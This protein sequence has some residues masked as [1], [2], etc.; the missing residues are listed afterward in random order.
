M[1]VVIS[2][3]AMR[4][5]L[6]VALVLG[7]SSG[8]KTEP[9]AGDASTGPKVVQ[10]GNAAWEKPGEFTVGHAIFSAKNGDRALTVQLWYP[11]RAPSAGTPIEDLVTDPADHATMAKLVE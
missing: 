2:S 5:S 7:C 10:Q 8:D 4:W 3:R 6:L 1:A 9:S 11:S